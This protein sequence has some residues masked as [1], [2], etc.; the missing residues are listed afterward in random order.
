[1]I[2]YKC[3]LLII[4]QNLNNPIENDIKVKRVFNGVKYM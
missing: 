4:C 1:M 3:E 2:V